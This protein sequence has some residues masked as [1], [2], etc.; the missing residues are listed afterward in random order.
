MR[1]L[2]ANWFDL[3][4]RSFRPDALTPR[5]Q[6]VILWIILLVCAGIHLW[7]MPSPA[8]DRTQWKEI[9]YLE[10]STNYWHHGF[11]FFHPEV[12][13]PADPPRVTAMEF[14][15]IPYLASLLYSIL[16]FNVYS[17]RVLPMLGFLLMTVYVFR[18]GKR[19]LGPIVGLLAA[20]AS[21]LMPLYHFY[22]RFL[23]SDST[24][25]AASVMTIYHFAEWVDFHRR[26]DWI[27]TLLA[28]TLAI[29]LKLYPLYLLLPLAWIVF[30]RYGWAPK[31]Y[32]GLLKLV[33]LALIL[34]ALWFAYALY[35]K[36]TSID[37]FYIFDD[38]KFET[39]MMWRSPGWYNTMW[40]RLQGILAGKVGLLLLAYGALGT[41]IRRRGALLYWYL[42]AILGY[43]GLMA[44]SN[45]GASYYQWP[46]MPPFSLFI[47]VGAIFTSTCVLSVIFLIWKSAAQRRSVFMAIVLLGLMFVSVMGVKRR[48][49][50]FYKQPLQPADQDKWAIAQV[51][52]ANSPG[53]GKLLTLGE[54]ALYAHGR[55]DLS[56][57]LYY[58]S[59][60]QGWS[61]GD[62]QWTPE[63]IK[64]YIHRGAAFFAA[65]QITRIPQCRPFLKILKKQY[66][67]LVESRD[68]LLFDLRRPVS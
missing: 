6:K 12:S 55:H 24:M 50:I 31:Q 42:L 22:G 3:I 41:I 26:R 20:F 18:L 40:E 23:F 43:I 14:P 15:I 4:D 62:N 47:A 29:A 67:V 66:P 44:Q 16:G 36:Y 46:I 37:L 49:D 8:L 35:V 34:P 53:N 13:W 2:L 21:S 9:D 64:D 39:L 17:V 7:T 48:V 56:P 30:R 60:L 19:E 1:N 57:V 58:Y 25:V 45:E 52:R 51:I 28:F 27:I 54:Y 63:E 65:E 38:R 33:L 68:Y 5:Q 61:L 59:G 11:N 32:G 10:I